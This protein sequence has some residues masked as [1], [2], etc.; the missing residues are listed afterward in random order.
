MST[1]I[2]DLPGPKEVFHEEYDE[3]HEDRNEEH[4]QD[5]QDRQD[6]YEEQDQEQEHKSQ[7]VHVENFD[8]SEYTGIIKKKNTKESKKQSMEFDLK[9]E[10]NIENLL[11]FFI[12]FSATLPQLNEGIR[13]VLG[14]FMSSGYSHGFITVIKCILL[15]SVFIIAKKFIN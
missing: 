13:K 2:S 15:V 3:E 1:F 5:R 9:N 10:L 8:E 12:I 6:E 11:L 7:T 4:H 14:M